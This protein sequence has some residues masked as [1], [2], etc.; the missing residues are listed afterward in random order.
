VT[1]EKAVELLNIYGEAWEKQDPDLILTIFTPSATYDDPHM[2]TIKRG[3][4]G[5]RAYWEDNCAL[6]QKDIQFWLLNTWTDGD[7]VIAEWNAKFTDIRRSLKI[8]LTGVLILTVED[9][10]FSSL[11]E[12]YKSV[13]TSL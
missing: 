10:K 9:D 11:R 4:E 2:E 3:H 1:K 13:K 6:G 12:Y 5:I 7:V 8:E